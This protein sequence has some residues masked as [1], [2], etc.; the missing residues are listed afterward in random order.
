MNG[1]SDKRELASIPRRS[2]RGQQRGRE[3]KGEGEQAV[4]YIARASK[5]KKNYNP[6]GHSKEEGKEG[7]EE[8]GA[9]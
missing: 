7:K 6:E 5:G 1:S 9:V 3:D 2:T 8:K 4:V